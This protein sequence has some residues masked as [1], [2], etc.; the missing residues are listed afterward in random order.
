MFSKRI[1]PIFLLLLGVGVSCIA[2]LV[3]V[4]TVRSS[5][6]RSL[7]AQVDLVAGLL[8]ERLRI[9]VL[10]SNGPV[11]ESLMESTL[12]SAPI[13]RAV[14]IGLDGKALASW[15]RAA[16]STDSQ[17]PTIAPQ[18]QTDYLIRTGRRPIGKLVLEPQ[19][20]G[21]L[22][23]ALGAL[24]LHTLLPLLLGIVAYV[25]LRVNSADR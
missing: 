5:E 12:A 17:A 9:A 23:P 21:P 8:T 19:A 13:Q 20:S 15:S 16:L 25:L 4:N 14:V 18:K 7:Q 6:A 2:G 1:N 24:L 10:Q 22:V 3:H 11:C